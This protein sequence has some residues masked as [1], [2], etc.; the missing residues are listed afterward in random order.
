MDTL[1]LKALILL[2]CLNTNAEYLM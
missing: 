2:S 1:Q